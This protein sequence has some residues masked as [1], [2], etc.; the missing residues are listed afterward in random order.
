MIGLLASNVRESEKHR[1][2]HPGGLGLTA[3]A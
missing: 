3:F 1:L 2:R